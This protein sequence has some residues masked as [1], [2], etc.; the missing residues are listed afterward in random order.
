MQNNYLLKKPK[1]HKSS[2]IFN[3]PH[4]GRDYKVLSNISKINNFDIRSSEDFFV[5][6]FFNNV[7]EFGSYFLNANFP[8]A[9]VD[10]NR[11]HLE[12]DPKLFLSLPENSYSLTKKVQSGLGVIPRVV[13]EGKEIYDTV[14]NYEVAKSRLKNFYFPYHAKLK[15]IIELNLKKFGEVFIFDCHS[16]PHSSLSNI[17]CNEEDKPDIV[18]GNCYGTSCKKEIFDL[19]SQIFEN[20]GFK[21]YLNIPF[22]GGFITKHYGQPKESINSIQIEINRKLYMNEENQQKLKGFEKIKYKFQII[23]EQLSKISMLDH[24]LQQAAE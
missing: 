24:N 10:L 20:N 9:Y 16:M 1:K 2:V 8:R 11:S 7:D 17:F 18:L 13:G 23:S 15:K 4:S 5:D 21:V 22:C 3:C 6:E 12:I 19:V 14:L